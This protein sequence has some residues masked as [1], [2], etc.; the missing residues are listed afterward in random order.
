MS[1]DSS[2]T[3]PSILDQIS[4]IADAISSSPIAG[5]AQVV[6]GVYGAYSSHVMAQALI[7]VSNLV[8]LVLNEVKALQLEI[9]QLEQDDNLANAQAAVTGLDNIENASTELQDDQITRSYND[10]NLAVQQLYN[11][12]QNYNSFIL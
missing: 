5:V 11:H 4:D 2:P 7:Q 6:A 1:T 10:A 9:E 3:S 12:S 8:S